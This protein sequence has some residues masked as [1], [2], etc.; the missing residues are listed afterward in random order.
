MALLSWLLLL[1]LWRLHRT[2][3][4][5]SQGMLNV[6]IA[7]AKHTAVLRVMMC[8]LSGNLSWL[9]TSCWRGYW[10]CPAAK[11]IPE[12]V[13]LPGIQRWLSWSRAHW[14]TGPL[15]SGQFW[16]GHHTTSPPPFFP[17]PAHLKRLLS[18]SLLRRRLTWLCWSSA[19][20]SFHLEA[21]TEG[22]GVKMGVGCC[23]VHCSPASRL[24]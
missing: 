22:V 1:H 8:V 6:A 23:I 19:L 17:P 24:A 11:T 12:L 20:L 13:L 5:A 21:T 15:S 14:S 3:D 2:S 9:W 7:V 4:N 10:L 16:L 18:Q